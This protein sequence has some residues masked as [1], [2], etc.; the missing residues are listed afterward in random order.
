V[1]GVP[2]VTGIVSEGRLTNNG[3]EC[4]NVE[5]SLEGQINLCLGT[6]E[7]HSFILILSLLFYVFESD[8]M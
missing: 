2:R 1:R 3:F 8:C 4:L 5:M 6:E 7:A